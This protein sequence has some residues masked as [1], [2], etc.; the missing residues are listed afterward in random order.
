MW[1]EEE[2]EGRPG[3]R[4]KRGENGWIRAV[5]MEKEIALAQGHSPRALC[6]PLLDHVS[7]LDQT[8]HKVGST[9]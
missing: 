3:G 5:F 9:Y 8:P 7:L 6:Q 1:G 2:K 4:E